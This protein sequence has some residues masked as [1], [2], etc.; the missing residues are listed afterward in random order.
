M[1]V[2]IQVRLVRPYRCDRFLIHA[3][4]FCLGQQTEQATVLHVRGRCDD[5]VAFAGCLVLS[6]GRDEPVS[7]LKTYGEPRD[8]DALAAAVEACL[9]ERTS[10]IH[11]EMR[12]IGG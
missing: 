3:L 10:I 8:T 5:G 7:D 11:D 1:T 6:E 2:Y 4:D 12:R 9:A